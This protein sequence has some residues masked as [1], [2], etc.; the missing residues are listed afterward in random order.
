MVSSRKVG[1]QR[2]TLQPT[3]PKD[4]EMSPRS[5]IALQKLG[6]MAGAFLA[7][8]IAMSAYN[9]GRVNLPLMPLWVNLLAYIGPLLAGG[10]LGFFLV[11]LLP[12]SCPNCRGPVQYR[13]CA[14][15]STWRMSK[16]V[17][18]CKNCERDVVNG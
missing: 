9:D 15:S 8:G 7:F 3:P 16:W 10:W 11:G 2:I 1:F 6:M 18:W 4:T 13:S 5:H 17:Y 12:I 14:T